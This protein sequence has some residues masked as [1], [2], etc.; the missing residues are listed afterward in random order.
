[1]VISEFNS[2]SLIQGQC[3]SVAQWSRI[4]QERQDFP[5]LSKRRINR[6]GFGVCSSRP[7]ECLVAWYFGRRIANCPPTY[8]RSNVI[9]LPSYRT[10]GWHSRKTICK[11][12]VKEECHFSSANCLLI[13]LIRLTRKAIL[14]GVI[15]YNWVDSRPLKL[16]IAMAY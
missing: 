16:V 8:F 7:V 5:A 13:E 9:M 14:K 15:M 3:L 10:H 11:T 12:A 4:Y 6:H 2:W 1:M